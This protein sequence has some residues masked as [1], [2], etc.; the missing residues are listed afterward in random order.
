MYLQYSRDKNLLF[1]IPDFVKKVCE[2]V[3]RNKFCQFRVNF[4]SVEEGRGKKWNR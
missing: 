2:N 4:N 3:F 1:G